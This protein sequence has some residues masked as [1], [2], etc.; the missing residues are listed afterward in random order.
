[1][2]AFVTDETC[3]SPA[4]AALSRGCATAISSFSNIHIDNIFTVVFGVVGKHLQTP[5]VSNPDMLILH[6]P[7]GIDAIFVLCIAC[8]L[9]DRKER[10]RYRHIDEKSGYRQI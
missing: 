10:E 2:P 6:P 3:T 5:P 8:L 1:M 9:K 7:T 4:A